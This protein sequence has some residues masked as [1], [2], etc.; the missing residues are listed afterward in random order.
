VVLDQVRHHT[1]ED[2]HCGGDL[3]TKAGKE[4]QREPDADAKSWRQV[5]MARR[6][7][8]YGSSRNGLPPGRLIDRVDESVETT[9]G[10]SSDVMAVPPVHRVPARRAR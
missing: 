3:E 6:K 2:A 1:E 7:R 9:Q 5:P 8:L 4:P 10:Q